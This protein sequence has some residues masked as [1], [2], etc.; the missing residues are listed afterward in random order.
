MYVSLHH[1][2]ALA[3]IVGIRLDII[4]GRIERQTWTSEFVTRGARGQ[5]RDTS[6]PSESST[7]GSGG[8]I[9]AYSEPLAGLLIDHMGSALH[10][11]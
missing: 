8:L 2:P 6:D 7:R 4:L 9:V 3:K 5:D 11:F 1:L 10:L